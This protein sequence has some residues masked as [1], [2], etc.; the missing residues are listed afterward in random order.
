MM[1]NAI[2]S[3]IFTVKKKNGPVSL[4]GWPDLLWSHLFGKS[5][6]ILKSKLCILFSTPH[7]SFYSLAKSSCLFNHLLSFPAPGEKSDSKF[8]PIS[9]FVGAPLLWKLSSSAFSCSEDFPFTRSS[10]GKWLGTAFLTGPS[11]GTGVTSAFT[12]TGGG[13]T[14]SMR[15]REKCIYV[16]QKL[17]YRTRVEILGQKWPQCIPLFI[18]LKFHMKHK[19]K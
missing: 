17:K 18:T 9:A 1:S 3:Y 8:V 2:L 12:N 6:G 14:P 19:H 4:T 5:L 10:R 15:Q 13:W 7:Q 16:T 11:L